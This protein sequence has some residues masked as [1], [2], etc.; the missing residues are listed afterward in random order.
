MERWAGFSLKYRTTLFH[1]TFPE[2]RIAVTSLRRLY[3]KQGIKRKKVRQEKYLPPR[4]QASFKENCQKLRQ[5]LNE[6]REEGR[7]II[8]LDEI[9]FTKRSI[10]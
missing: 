10:Q 8:F 2:K 1:R 7:M 4:T 6:A 9:N 5:E 3:L